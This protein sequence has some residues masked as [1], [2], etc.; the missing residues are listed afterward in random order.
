MSVILRFTSRVYLFSRGGVLDL[1]LDVDD[2]EFSW[3]VCNSFFLGLIGPLPSSF[4]SG[5]MHLFTFNFILE[6]LR[7]SLS[8]SGW[9]R[10]SYIIISISHLVIIFPNVCLA[11][12][13]LFVILCYL[14][15]KEK[16]AEPIVANPQD[17][18]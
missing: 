17:I 7:L 2:D 14:P 18:K 5:E 8:M 12:V 16:N 9:F 13:H 1:R 6:S 15:K 3:W 10:H 4:A 11:F